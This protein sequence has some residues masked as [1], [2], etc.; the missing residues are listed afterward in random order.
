MSQIYGEQNIP[1]RRPSW[2]RRA[3]AVV[4]RNPTISIDIPSIENLKMMELEEGL[5]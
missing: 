5:S 1:L 2:P 4:I 3:S